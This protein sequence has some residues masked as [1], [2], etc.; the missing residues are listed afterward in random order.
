MALLDLGPIAF[1][2]TD[3]LITWFRSKRL[4]A[5]SQDCTSCHVPMRQGKRQD[6]TDGV[7]W[8]CPSCKAT[9]SIR[10]G[11]FFSKS[12]LTLQKWLLLMHFWI[13]QYP[14]KDAAD[15]VK[16]NKSTAF[17][18]YRWFREVCSTTLLGTPVILGGAGVVVQVDVS[19]FRHKPKVIIILFIL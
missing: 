4:L 2:P 13:R 15:D 1:G 16:V 5:R 17:D 9:K 14:V 7:V 12:R 6:V 8:R 10:A 11:S 3:D 18:I 19:L